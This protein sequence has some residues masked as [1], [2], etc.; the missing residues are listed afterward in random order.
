MSARKPR[1]GETGFEFGARV[2]KISVDALVE[3]YNTTIGVLQEGITV[4][5]TNAPL[6]LMAELAYFDL[7]HGGAYAAPQQLI[8]WHMKDRTKSPYYTGELQ[9]LP[10][11]VGADNYNEIMYDSNVPHVFPKLLSDETFGRIE[12]TFAQAAT[13]DFFK[14]F[15]TGVSTMVEGIGK[16]AANVGLGARRFRGGEE[17]DGGFTAT[18]RRNMRALL[19]RLPKG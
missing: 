5:K 11:G 6:G 13:I 14:N 9:A 7:L 4:G 12:I 1:A 18:D 15:S 16:G 2:L 3:I 8:P 10:Q 17:E 19:A